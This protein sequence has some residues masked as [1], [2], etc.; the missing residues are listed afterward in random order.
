MI[1]HFGVECE[2]CQEAVL[3]PIHREWADLEP[4]LIQL[5]LLLGQG[6]DEAEE[7]QAFFEEHEPH[8]AR[9]CVC[10]LEDTDNG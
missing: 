7:I 5:N 1:P 10:D 8:G 2:H 6:L 9:A 3:I 4:A